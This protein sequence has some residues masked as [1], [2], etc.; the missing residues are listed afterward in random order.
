MLTPRTMKYNFVYLGV[1]KNNVETF[2][3]RPVK[4]TSVLIDFFDFAF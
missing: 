3:N 1:R 2:D 4:N